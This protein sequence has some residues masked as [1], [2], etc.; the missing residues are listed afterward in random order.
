MI[1]RFVK[2][3][4]EEKYRQQF[5]EI[6]QEHRLKMLN[7]EIC[8]Q[9]DLLEDTKQNGLFFTHS[10]WQSEE[11]LQAYRDSNYF[12]QI[13][14]LVKPWFREKAEAWSLNSQTK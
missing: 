1:H 11:A 6:F 7:Q 9:L 8:I 5:I 3:T 12:N 14:S 4:F 13:W 10:I 2:L